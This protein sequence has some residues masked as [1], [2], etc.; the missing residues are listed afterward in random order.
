MAFYVT[1]LKY[2]ENVKRLKNRT[3]LRD[4]CLYARRDTREQHL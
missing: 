2:R 1:V 3:L 4:Q